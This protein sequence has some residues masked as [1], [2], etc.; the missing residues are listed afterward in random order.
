MNKSTLE[1]RKNALEQAIRDDDL[2]AVVTLV[3]E[4]PE[5]L[6]ADIRSRNSG[7]PLSL[8]ADLGKL[9]IVKA[10]LRFNPPDFERAFGRASLQGHLDIVRF[11]FEQRPQ[12]GD[13][14]KFAL[15][16][17]CEALKA[18]AIP[19]LIELGA[20]PNAVWENG[21]TPLDMAICSY[22][23]EG[24]PACIEA[25]VTGGV[26]YEESPEMDIHRGRLDL[27]TTRLDADPALVHRP[28]EFRA[29]KEYG[30]LYGGAPLI[31]PT[32]LHICAEFGALAAAQLLIERGADLDA[33]CLPDEHGIGDQTPIF[34]AVASNNNHAFPVLELLVA[35]GADLNARATVRVPST[36]LQSVL[37]DDPLL[38]NVTPLG[39]ALNYPN[40]EHHK[41][42]EDAIAF[43]RRHGGVE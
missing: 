37:P 27:L 2:D 31:R 35:K 15:F 25:L 9:E 8:A 19:L 17:P 3:T 33:R 7:P 41:P 26:D 11:L 38:Q 34:H 24:R 29:G 16:G 1:H 13:N 42:H 6:T 21:G 18:S 39:Y 14:L 43:L 4:H 23:C 28:S 32:L 40:D 5:L 10:L 20:D 22:M 30:G 12:L 36:G